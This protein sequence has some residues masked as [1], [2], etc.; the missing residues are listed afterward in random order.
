MLGD[1]AM[2]KMAGSKIFI[3]GLGG[4]GVEIGQQSSCPILTCSLHFSVAK[5]VILA[6]VKVTL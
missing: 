2:H 3:T 6:G 1:T 5:N 4:L